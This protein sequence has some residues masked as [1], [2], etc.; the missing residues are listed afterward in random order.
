MSDSKLA[1]H[2]PADSSVSSTHVVL[3]PFTNSHGTAFGGQIM[4]WMDIAAG[5]AA[6]RHSRNPVVTVS[7]EVFSIEALAASVEWLAARFRPSQF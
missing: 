7:L 2:P 5:I 6:N 4:A 1:A 3:P